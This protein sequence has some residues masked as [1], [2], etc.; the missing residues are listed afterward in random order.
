MYSFY[1][2]PPADE[3]DRRIAILN[4]R[5]NVGYSV[6]TRATYEI[7]RTIDIKYVTVYPDPRPRSNDS[8]MRF[9]AFFTDHEM[10]VFNIS[11][12]SYENQYATNIVAPNDQRLIS[13]V[14]HE[15][16]NMMKDE[17]GYS[18]SAK[19][20]INVDTQN[21][22]KYF[23]TGYY[24]LVFCDIQASIYERGV[25]PTIDMITTK[26]LEH[27]NYCD[28]CEKIEFGSDEKPI[29]KF[30]EVYTVKTNIGKHFLC[31]SCLDTLT[32]ACVICDDLVYKEELAEE[33]YCYNCKNKCGHCDEHY[34]ARNSNSTGVCEKCADE[35]YHFCISCEKYVITDQEDGDGNDVCSSCLDNYYFYCEDCET[36]YPNS[37]EIT[38]TNENGDSVNIC[39][40]CYEGGEYS[41]CVNCG[42]IF[43]DSACTKAD[44]DYMYC[45]SCYEDLF[46]HCDACENE[47]SRTE[48][49]DT[50]IDGNYCQTCVD[51]NTCQ[52][53]KNVVLSPSNAEANANP[54]YTVICDDCNNQLP[55]KHM[56]RINGF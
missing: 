8:L 51:N 16:I 48:E 34:D 12:G 15:Y 17:H 2:N 38:A 5:G 49:A 37:E 32:A 54:E 24:A 35:G 26:M 22:R 40:G 56:H 9:D 6:Y 30:L 53:C 7:M 45:N 41:C 44:N 39:D 11:N 33:K 42:E 1:H 47:C 14:L 25:I 18:I 19:D 50:E 20:V 52:R 46:F 29:S 13:D 23:E 31:P 28:H 3:L 21:L 55:Y 43:T 27:T 10:F 4:K 36:F